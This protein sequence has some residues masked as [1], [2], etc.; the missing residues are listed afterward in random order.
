MPRSVI[1]SI[2]RTLPMEPL[3][4]KRQRPLWKRIRNLFGKG[5]YTPCTIA[6]YLRKHGARVG[7]GCFIG[8]TDIEGEID[9]RLLEIGNHVAMASG[10]SFVG[11][12]DAP[13]PVIIADNCF[14]GFRARIHPNVRIGPNSVVGAG[15]VVRSD[16][17]PN[18]LV[19]GAPARPFGSLEKHRQKCIERWN[20]QRPSGVVIEPHETW[21]STRHLAANRE[22][23]KQHL[24]G[25]FHKQLA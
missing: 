9:L 8:P 24:L 2:R 14:I 25:L 21:W 19:I 3:V 1:E 12:R 5:R 10:V 11:Q 23:L 17:P 13:G 6:A 4:S 18:T 16:V 7:D 22:R 20:E 15:S